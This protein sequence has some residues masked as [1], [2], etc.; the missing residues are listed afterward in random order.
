MLTKFLGILHNLSRR[1]QCRF[2]FTSC[3]A[4]EIIVPLLK[5]EVTLF[6]TKALL[7]LAHLIDEKNNEMIMS[8][9]GNEVFLR[10]SHVKHLCQTNTM[11]IRL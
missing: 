5:A 10:V 1:T 3:G 2:Y 4:V 8:D 9:K 11:E 6:A 7:I